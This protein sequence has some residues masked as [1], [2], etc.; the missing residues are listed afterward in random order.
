MAE[1]NRIRRNRVQNRSLTFGA[2]PA[3][4]MVFEDNVLVE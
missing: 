2:T 1:D 4:D 3:I